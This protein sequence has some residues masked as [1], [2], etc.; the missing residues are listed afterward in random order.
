MLRLSRTEDDDYLQNQ[1][2]R[3]SKSEARVVLLYA[4][5][6]DDYYAIFVILFIDTVHLSGDSVAEWLACWTQA[7]TEEPGFKSQSR[8]Y[9]VTV[10]GKPFTPTVSLF[11]EQRNW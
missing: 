6:Y 11:T 4:T 8:R 3:L 5:Q 9:R 7:Q 10:L 1:L 2:L